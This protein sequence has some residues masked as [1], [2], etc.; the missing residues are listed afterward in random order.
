MFTIKLRSISS[1]VRVSCP[2]KCVYS[3]LP[4]FVLFKK[5][6][7]DVQKMIPSGLTPTSYGTQGSSALHTNSERRP[8]S[9]KLWLHSDHPLCSLL[10]FHSLFFHGAIFTD[11]FRWW[12]FEPPQVVLRGYFWLC[13]QRATWDAGDWTGPGCVQG[14][15]PDPYCLSSPSDLLL[16]GMVCHIHQE[17]DPWLCLQYSELSTLNWT[18]TPIKMHSCVFD[19]HVTS[20]N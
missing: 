13:A 6:V 1:P 17:P 7:D 12:V 5:L 15:S 19:I 14:K 8:T 20:K 16:K 2:S 11:P 3:Q 10:Q 4:G 18:H 9:E